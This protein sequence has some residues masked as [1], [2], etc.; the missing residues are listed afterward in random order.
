MTTILECNSKT[1][2]Y[3]KEGVRPL[4]HTVGNMREK[5]LSGQTSFKSGA[6]ALDQRMYF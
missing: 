2:P 5:V 6:E 3:V 1:A 4:A